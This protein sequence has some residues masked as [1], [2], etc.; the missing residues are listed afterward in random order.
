MK[1]E[2]RGQQFRISMSPRGHSHYAN[3]QDCARIE[4]RSEEV[5]KESGGKSTP[6]RKG[7]KDTNYKAIKQE[8]K[9]RSL[10]SSPDARLQPIAQTE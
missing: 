2:E 1:L 6:K 4:D 10:L 5:M 8:R 9:E 7:S 3:L